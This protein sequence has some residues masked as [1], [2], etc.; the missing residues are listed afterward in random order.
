[1]WEAYAMVAQWESLVEGSVPCEREVAGSNPAYR[2]LC[3]RHTQRWRSGKV[4]LSMVEGSVPCEREVAGSNPAY[5]FLCGR[6]TQRWRSGK[7]LLSMVEGSVRIST[8]FQTTFPK[9]HPCQLIHT[10]SVEVVFKTLPMHVLRVCEKILP[11]KA[12]SCSLHPI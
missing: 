5:R 6:H 10:V 8:L 9:I 2:F 12:C 4:L 7:V 3:G 11:A 1:M